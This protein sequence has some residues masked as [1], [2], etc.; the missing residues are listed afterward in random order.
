[1]NSEKILLEISTNDDKSTVAA[2]LVMNGYT[3]RITKLLTNGRK[4]AFLEAWKD[5]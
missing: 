2:I 1:M 4:K 3:V 5:E